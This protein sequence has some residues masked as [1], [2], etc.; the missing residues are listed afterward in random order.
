M[1]D[2]GGDRRSSTAELAPV[3]QVLAAPVVAGVAGVAVG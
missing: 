1:L 2:R 3:V